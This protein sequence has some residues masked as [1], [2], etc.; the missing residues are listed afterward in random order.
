M[1]IPLVAIEEHHQAFTVWFWAR[2]QKMLPTEPC[3]LL[4]VDTH[5]DFHVPQLRSSLN[6]LPQELCAIK[7]FTNEELTI[8]S[9]IVPAIYLELFD[10]VTWL[11]GSAEASASRDKI[12]VS[13]VGEEQIE[14]LFGVY[15]NKMRTLGNSDA[16]IAELREIQDHEKLETERDIVLD[17]DLDYFLCN[18]LTMPQQCKLE[19]THDCFHSFLNDPYHP[20]RLT[21][22]VSV[23]VFQQGEQYFADF[24]TL[25]GRGLESPET[26]TTQ[27]KERLAGFESFLE[28]LEQI[29][30]LILLARSRYSG[31]TP[32]EFS[33]TIET[34]V[35]DILNRLYTTKEH[36]WTDI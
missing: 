23:R 4:H 34:G 11:S 8:S 31:Y 36:S 18:T 6:R 25:E 12:F 26:A 15:G 5:S 22:G 24:G 10:Q 17:I 32:W 20:L 2:E 29:P 1:S 9:F 33:D 21:P 28:Q 16:R 13:S 30:K 27:I 7:R 35:R 14:L 3:H 19:I